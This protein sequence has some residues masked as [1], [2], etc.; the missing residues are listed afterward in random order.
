MREI[1]TATVAGLRGPGLTAQDRADLAEI[2][3]STIEAS[4]AAEASA[5]AVAQVIDITPQPAASLIARD[6]ANRSAEILDVSGMLSPD[7]LLPTHADPVLADLLSCPAI[8][9]AG[10]FTAGRAYAPGDLLRYR[11]AFYLAYDPV[12]AS[13]RTP[14]AAPEYFEPVPLLS[15]ETVWADDDFSVSNANSPIAGRETREGRI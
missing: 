6:S 15:R 11:G 12:S 8:R 1:F 2:Q 13:S 10:E 7:R 3:A 4:E 9:W 5:A 14:D